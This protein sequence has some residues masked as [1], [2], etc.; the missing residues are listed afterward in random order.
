[1]TVV[2]FDLVSPRPERADAARNREKILR[3]AAELF[4][5]DGVDAV[6][7]D[8]V[9]RAAG[10]SKGTLF[11][12]FGSRAGL[13]M[14]LLDEAE[15]ELQDGL[16]RGPAPL[17]PGAPPAERLAAFF[18]A[19]VDLLSDHHAL[20]RTSEHGGPEGRRLGIGAY[21]AWHLHVT[22]LLREAG[23]VADPELTAHLLLAMV[24]SELY[25]GLG[26]D[27]AA[28]KRALAAISTA[29]TAAGP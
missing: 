21:A 24:D 2:K 13:A 7:M 14:A 1:L 18:A 26:A 10:V 16:L 11:H 17:G 28:L 9:A 23:A 22:M 25:R 19:Y 8:A 5:R 29:A 3:A 20:I 6:S 4:E 15:R 12:R 27:D